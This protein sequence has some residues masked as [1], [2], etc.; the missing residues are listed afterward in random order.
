MK[1]TVTILIFIFVL[2]GASGQQIE[3]AVQKGHSGDITFV[4]FN[5][6]GLLLATSGSDHLIKLWHVPT[7]KEMASFVS[8]YS[9][10]VYALKF[11]AEDDFLYVRYKDGTVYT[12]NVATS[13]LETTAPPSQ[14][15]TFHDQRRYVGADSLHEVYVREYYL[16]KKSRSSG[17]T[18]FSKVPMDISRH[19]TSVAVSELH[20]RV[21]AGSED[22]KVYVYDYAKGR[23]VAMLGEHYTSVN[24]IALSPDESTFATASSDR[25]V[26]LWDIRT[27][28]RVRRLY[29]RSFRYESLAF[30]ATGSVLAVGDELGN[31]K[32]IDLKSSRVNVVSHRW[33]EHKISAIRFSH[34]N[35]SIFSAGMDNR[36]QVFDY[37]EQR[38][39]ERHTYLDYV[40]FGDFLLKK[41]GAYREPYAWVNTLSVSPGDKYLMAGGAW[42]ESAVRGK[43]Q[44]LWIRDLPGDALRKVRAHRGSIGSVAF[45]TP[46]SFISASGNTMLEWFMD[47]S[48]NSLNYREVITQGAV[49]RTLNVLCQ[50]T[51]VVHTDAGID[52]RSLKTGTAVDRVTAAKIID[53]VGVHPN[54]KRQIAYS[55]GT[56]LYIQ[57]LDFNLSREAPPIIIGR[58]HTD[59]ITGIAFSPTRPL[60]ATCGWDAA[61][62]I[63]DTNTGELL[64]TI[65]SVGKD[66][67][68]II[69]PDGYY[70]GTRNS[71]RA[72]GY[73][74]GK[75]FISP[76]QF[77]LRFNRP[78]LVLSRLGFVPEQVIRAYNRAYRKRLQK[79]NFSEDMLGADVHLPQIKITT[80][81]LPLKT[82][83]D[84]IDFGIR[85]TDSKYALDRVNVFV[86]NIPVYGLQGINVREQ[87]QHDLAMQVKLPLSAGKNK[88]Q[89]SC[90]N[91][92]GVE[93]LMETF[94]IERQE[95]ATK[96][97]LYLAIISVSSY[98]DPR[99][100]LKYAVKDGRDLM[101]LFLRR[102]S[103]Y[104][105]I[106]SDSLTNRTATRE[107]ILALK[108]KFSRASVDDHVILFVSGHGL[109]DDKLDFYFATHDID[110]SRPSER[111]I[112]YDELENLLDGIP[113]RKKLLLIDACHSGEV[114]KTRLQVSDQ[115]ATLARNQKGTVKTYT[116]PAEVIEEHHQVGIKTSFELMQELFANVSK[117]SGAVV[118]AAAAGNSYA[119]ESDEWRNGV[120]T[121]AVLSGLKNRTA[122]IN[123]N[124]DISVTE[125]KDFTSKEVQRLTKGEQKPTSRRENLEF[126]FKIW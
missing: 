46:S 38:V 18:V 16:R 80:E 45:V 17:K 110:F 19:F 87:Q 85:A 102:N 63:W 31:A 25:S 114:D 90:L 4:T 70:F 89:V 120:F 113:A 59:R 5:A 66:D 74:Y 123:R 79:M 81:R 32:I 96:P 9:D 105:R 104:N 77:D 126:D 37:E 71:L 14:R 39:V 112:R 28:Q 26:I 7:G 23:S 122:D 30:D 99:M 108:E 97:D 124:G 36:I 44:P 67:H 117:G 84:E 1:I 106:Y 115:S 68:M 12:W 82:S 58:A 52:V 10:D 86:N 78:D 101:S 43:P 60:L 121:Y 21:V 125:L 2:A 55:S 57:T 40:S 62:K 69:T 95:K 93:S 98:L 24:S 42:R 76:E 13:L 83:G 6:S 54:N 61:V 27:L 51:V 3:I 20:N 119:L 109:L 118:I 50:D 35:K 65:V 92:K 72:I 103:Y 73:K 34:D 41:I 75:Q 88:I 11:S 100:N 64:A 53:A 8:T 91:E 22:G 116:Y 107:N 48:D 56:D 47:P 94:E 29:G 49:I 15:V 33:H 111:G